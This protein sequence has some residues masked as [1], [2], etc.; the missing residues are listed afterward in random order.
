[1]RKPQKS[2]NFWKIGLIFW[3]KILKKW[4]PFMAKITLKDGYGFWGSSG[5]PLSNSHLSTHPRLGKWWVVALIL[6]YH[7]CNWLYKPKRWLIS[8]LV[9]SWWEFSSFLQIAKV[10]NKGMIFPIFNR[11]KPLYNF[12][13]DFNDKRGVIAKAFTLNYFFALTNPSHGTLLVDNEEL[14]HWFIESF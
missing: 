13:V 5:T 4:V 9:N 3:R 7:V 14:H 2:R 10:N 12:N 6:K 8:F 1:M 11:H